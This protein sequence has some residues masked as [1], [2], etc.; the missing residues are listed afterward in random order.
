MMRLKDYEDT[1]DFMKITHGIILSQEE[2]KRRFVIRHLLIRPGM[3]LGRY[4]ELFGSDALEDFPV[5]NQWIEQRFATQNAGAG[6]RGT[7]RCIT[8]T[9]SGLG[10][11]DYLGP[12]FISPEVK[13]AMQEWEAM[14][15][16]IYG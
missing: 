11:S 12:Q 4:Q 1:Q 8:L 14:H 13:K 10:L 5:L 3:N 6:Q 9:E 7:E 16:S 15:G 2:Q